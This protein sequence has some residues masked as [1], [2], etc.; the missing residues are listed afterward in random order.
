MKFKI[1]LA[2]IFV[3]MLHHSLAAEVA[4]FSAPSASPPQE[5]ELP[6][7]GNGVL[8]LGEICD[9]GNRAGGD[10]CNAWCSAFDSMPSACTIAGRN[11][12]CPFGK[13]V[14]GGGSPSKAIFC[15]L[16]ALAV[17]PKGDYAILAD[18]SSLLKLDLFTDALSS[19][20]QIFPVT[21]EK[22]F[23]PICSVFVFDDDLSIL[24]Y[25]CNVKT[26][27]RLSLVSPDG[28][29]GLTIANLNH[30]F[31][32]TQ[33]EIATKILVQSSKRRAVVAG[34]ASSA[35]SSSTNALTG[36][37]SCVRVA[38]VDVPT[39]KNASST[40][41]QYP[42]SI[43]ADIP[44]IVYN[45]LENE[46]MYPTFSMKGMTPKH[47]SL[48]TCPQIYLST[49]MCY[50]V[51]MERANDMQWVE[52]FIP[53]TGG[54]D[55]MYMAHTD[56]L[57]NVYLADPITRLGSNN[58]N[59]V[60]TLTSNCLESESKVMTVKGKVPPRTTLG[61]AC[62]NGPSLGMQC[63]LPLN[64]P[65]VTDIINS[66]YLLPEGLS[67]VLT[68]HDL[69]Q[70]FSQQSMQAQNVSISGATLY[71]QILNNL[72]GNSTP[73][74]FVEI[75]NT[76]DILYVTPISVGLV[77]T[78]RFKLS[79]PDNPGYCRATNV[80]YCP[81]G[82]YGDVKMGTCRPCTE[83]TAPGY[84]RSFAW[85][86]MCSAIVPS[87]NNR[88]LLQQT[89]EGDLP[90]E[91]FSMLVSKDIDEKHLNDAICI[92]LATK[93]MECPPYTQS[94][95]M[96]PKQ[97]YNMAADNA[98][99]GLL[100]SSQSGNNLISSLIRN[101]EERLGYSLSKKASIA[102]YTT[103][104]V[105]KG[106]SIVESLSKP[107]L[108]LSKIDISKLK[109]NSNVSAQ[110]WNTTEVRLCMY[111]KSKGF[112]RGWLEC[113]LPILAS[114]RKSSGAN[115][116][117]F[118]TADAAEGTSA[119]EYQGISLLSSKKALWN[120]SSAPPSDD[121]NNGS[122]GGSQ[123]GGEQ[124]PESFP[125]WIGVLIGVVCCVVVIFLLYFIYSRRNASG[126]YRQ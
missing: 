104:W 39:F 90:S 114:A 58:N 63:A 8:D 113:I 21:I 54:L 74:D 64:N 62:K 23:S 50:K 51:T 19:S 57:E 91:T 29:I 7:C 99:S 108:P 86:V 126:R 83:T 34:I 81:Q 124:Q 65:F 9:D 26:K 31:E 115:R 5:S 25:E 80:I 37:E 85:Q 12:A 17:H 96:T 22:D 45:V 47:V 97:Q 41:D 93:N 112:I 18:S 75:P 89:L 68:H 76:M 32:P 59:M 107:D 15:N 106:T 119:V 42:A 52:A 28:T 71:K 3:G 116:R 73:V 4:C 61:S 30:L 10:G 27:L 35:G 67:S 53:E 120:P 6:L 122:G 13:T 94:K 55:I 66:P 46:V 123:G 117:L 82:S 48:A 70:I 111:S 40:A 100:S 79:D 14:L 102:E 78:K 33:Q 20:L 88:R 95:T 101:T 38:A 60:Y 109:L 56:L 92:W 44:C 121:R 84:G 2:G 1:A 36:F 11:M 110:L 69:M 49:S 87:A 98:D 103:S 77:S 43:I 118:Q 72:Y 125:L 105:S 24:T 16:R